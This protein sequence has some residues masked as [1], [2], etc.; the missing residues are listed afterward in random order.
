MFAEYKPVRSVGSAGAGQLV[1]PRS[2]PTLN[3]FK[4]KLK[5]ALFS[6]AF[7]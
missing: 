2:A 6:T 4:K 7:Y 3:S 5:I 1:V